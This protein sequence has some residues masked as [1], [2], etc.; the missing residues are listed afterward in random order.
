M[1]VLWY[2][3]STSVD[4]FVVGDEDG[5]AEIEVDAGI[6]DA[7]MGGGGDVV[8]TASGSGDVRLIGAVGGDN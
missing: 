7:E 8:D 2:S 1:E 3:V 4:E 6:F 5:G